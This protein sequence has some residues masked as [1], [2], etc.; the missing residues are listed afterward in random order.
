MGVAEVERGAA[1]QA[2]HQASDH[3]GFVEAD[4]GAAADDEVRD[5]KR[6]A[7]ALRDGAATGH[8]AEAEQTAAKVARGQCRI[9]QQAAAGEQRVCAAKADVGALDEAEQ[10]LVDAERRAAGGRAREDFNCAVCRRRGK[11]DKTG[12]AGAADD[13]C[14][15]KE[16]VVGAEFYFRSLYGHAADAGGKV[17]RAQ[18]R[19]GPLTDEVDRS[20]G[21][22]LDRVAITRVD[23]DRSTA[24]EC[25]VTVWC[26]V[27]EPGECGAVVVEGVD[28]RQ[29][30]RVGA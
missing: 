12:C 3:V 15:A 18:C 25:D 20:C 26:K 14:A 22:D 16:E 24:L 21:A 27:V 7:R 2:C 19:G 6:R 23:R 8:Q 28:D 4:T 10:A 1:G 11:A 9:D 13:C 5:R 29:S 30:P 17:D